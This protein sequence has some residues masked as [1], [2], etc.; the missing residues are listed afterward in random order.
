[1]KT[2]QRDE[3]KEKQRLRKEGI[4]LDQPADGGNEGIEGED[5]LFGGSDAGGM[6][7]D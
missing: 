2:A 4:D 1:M 7:L 5:D 6:D 3:L